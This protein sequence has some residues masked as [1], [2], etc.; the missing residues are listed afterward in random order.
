MSCFTLPVIINL[1]E[2]SPNPFR[3]FRIRPID[4]E[5]VRGLK[6]SIEMSTFWGGVPCRKT[7]NGYEIA[8]GHQRV[9]A[10]K[11]AGIEA[12]EFFV[13]N[14]DDAAMVW[15][16]VFENFTQRN[17]APLVTVAAGAVAAAIRFLASQGEREIDRDSI[18]RCLHDISGITPRLVDDQLI[19]LKMS[20]EYHR[21]IH[22]EEDS[23]RNN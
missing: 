15:A 2:L 21:I 1:S 14:F 3:D 12:A 9:E 8:A 20:G 17:R 18:L 4:E 19:N 23:A 5:T 10:A 16:Y 22:E 13:G 6:S 7:A 11:M